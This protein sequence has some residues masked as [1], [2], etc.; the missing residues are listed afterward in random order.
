MWG[1]RERR[2]A[3]RGRNIEGTGQQKIINGCCHAFIG[4]LKSV[5]KAPH[6]FFPHLTISCA[7]DDVSPALTSESACPVGFYLSL[8]D[9][10]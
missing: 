3:Q 8:L 2:D 9:S 6:P 5:F 7:E 4:T 10:P 1:E